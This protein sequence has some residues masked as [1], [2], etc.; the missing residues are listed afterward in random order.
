M[1]AVPSNATRSGQYMN[2]L[3]NSAFDWHNIVFAVNIYLAAVLALFV[4]VA[5]SLDLQNPW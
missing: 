1:V 3:L 4:F 2:R 5:F